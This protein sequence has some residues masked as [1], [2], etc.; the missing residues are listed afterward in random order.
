M[1]KYSSVCLSINAITRLLGF[2]IIY[3][4]REG[5][6]AFPLKSQG[7]CKFSPPTMWG[8]RVKFRAS[9]CLRSMLLYL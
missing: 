8:Q 3:Y 5:A 2:Y 9:L 4:E 7:S 6:I 1:F